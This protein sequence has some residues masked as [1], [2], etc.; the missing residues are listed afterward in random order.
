MNR[1]SFFMPTLSIILPIYNTEKYIRESLE[2]ILHQT[3]SDFEIICVDDGSTDT[4]MEIV[5][6]IADMDSAG[7][8]V[9][10]QLEKNSGIATARNAGIAT[11]RGTFIAFADADDIWK[12]KKLELQMAQFASDPHLDISFCMIQNFISPELSDEEKSLK[13]ILLE[14]ISGQVSGAFLAKK[15]S[16]D[17]V[18][19]LN[20]T[21]R[22]GEF[23]DWMARASDLGLKNNIIPEVLYLRRAHTTNTT[24]DKPAHTDYLTIARQALLRRRSQ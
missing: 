1:M 23:I 6:E 7:R 10:V 2:S 13:N 16:F 19:L 9:T 8:I 12:P 18:G 22:I 17:Q 5:R 24:L 4:S 14:P 20:A 15:S 21:Y 11:A 3:Y